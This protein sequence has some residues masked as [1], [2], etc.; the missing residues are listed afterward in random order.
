MNPEEFRK[1]LTQGINGSVSAVEELLS[2]YEP[3]I[4]KYSSI[5]G[6]IDEDLRETIVLRILRNLSSFKIDFL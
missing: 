2:L 1:L 6:V 3:L 4:T 5:A